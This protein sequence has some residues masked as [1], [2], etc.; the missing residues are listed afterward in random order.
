MEHCHTQLVPATSNHSVICHPLAQVF[1]NTQALGICSQLP[2]TRL[3]SHLQASGG[4]S[5]LQ[6][7]GGFSHLQASGGL[8]HLQ[9]P[10][11]AAVQ[12]SGVGKYPFL[13]LE[14]SQ[15]QFGDVLVGEQVEQA[16]QLLNQGLVP[17]DFCM[18]P[19][20]ASN[21]V[22][23]DTI[24]VSPTRLGLFKGRCRYAQGFLNKLSTILLSPH[25]LL[26]TWLWTAL[27]KGH[28]RGEDDVSV[29][30]RAIS[31]LG[32][33]SADTYVVAVLCNGQWVPHNLGS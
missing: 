21:G 31:C 10:L 9:D 19:L 32:R 15:L 12:V 2:C 4:L 7:S 24:R 5:Q 22:A 13:A 11:H 28:A 25:L 29:S 17:A 6:A 1:F 23:D 14:R 26:E 27:S 16:V 18:K 30:Q 3:Q 33:C 20:L 8:S